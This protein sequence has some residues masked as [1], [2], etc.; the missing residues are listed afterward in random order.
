MMGEKNSVSQ[1]SYSLA[2]SRHVKNHVKIVTAKS[3]SAGRNQTISG[4]AAEIDVT[5]VIGLVDTGSNIQGFVQI[6]GISPFLSF[7]SNL[8]F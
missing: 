3:E 8:Y 6:A 4:V 2:S 7:V 5:P 1:D